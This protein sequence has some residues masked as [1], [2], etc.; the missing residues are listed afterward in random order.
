MISYNKWSNYINDKWIKEM[1]LNEE[2]KK[3]SLERN[4]RKLINKKYKPIF[5]KM[6][7]YE[8]IK[9]YAR[10]FIPVNIYIKL[11]ELKNI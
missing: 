7:L 9:T 1:I 2:F 3:D 10:C 8:V 5:K 4:F 11:H 6:S